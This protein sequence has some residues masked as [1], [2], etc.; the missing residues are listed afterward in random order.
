MR[1]KARRLLRSRSGSV[2]AFTAVFLPATLG[3][4][5]LAI[6]L[7]MLRQAHL[8]A[9]RAADFAALA[10]A[11][12]YLDIVPATNA[13]NEAQSRA[14][15][16]AIVNDIKG[17]TIDSAEVTLQI[18]P[19]EFQVYVH[20]RRENIPTLFARF[21]GTWL[22]AVSADATAEATAAGGVQCLRPLALP[23]YWHDADNDLNNNRIWDADETWGWNPGAGD[24]YNEAPGTIP[25]P[26]TGFGSDYRNTYGDIPVTNDQGRLLIL[27]QPNGNRTVG[28]PGWFYPIRIDENQ[29]AQEYRDSFT[30]C[31]PGT[32]AVGDSIREE[33]G[34]MV[35][36]TEHAVMDVL[37]LDPTGHY[38]D[39]DWQD[40]PRALLLALFDPHQIPDLGGNGSVVPTNFAYFWLEGFWNDDGTICIESRCRTQPV[41]GRFM[42]YAQGV[43]TPSPQ[44]GQLV[45]TLRLVQ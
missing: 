21:L 28:T 17:V 31:V 2:L 4:M 40:S 42:Q 6:D 10:G 18:R 25:D 45:R 44:T 3:T 16:Y 34:A 15:E 11:S 32:H 29:G 8:Q 36:P 37:A 14:Y 13:V 24:F 26:A 12:A 35:G 30:T 5:A 43:G 33:N 27:K 19:D 38:T 39:A 20:I 1:K 7:G 22:D 9:Q 23:D 41:V